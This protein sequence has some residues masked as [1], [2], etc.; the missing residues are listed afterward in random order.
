MKQQTNQTAI[1]WKEVKF[2]EFID[3]ND[4]DHYTPQY[5]DQGVPLI[6][7]KDFQDA[8][9]NLT[10]LKFVS[11]KELDNF[12][13]KCNPKKGDIL[14]S[15]IGTIGVPKIIDFDFV[16]LHSIAVIKSK[17]KEIDNKFLYYLLKSPEIKR[18]AKEGTKSIGTPDLGLNEIRNFKIKIPFLHGSPDLETQQKIV[19][20]LEKAEQL[21]EKRKQTLKLL[22]EYLKSVFNEMFVGKGF[23]KRK[24]NELFELAYGKGLSDKERDG[25]KYQVYGS[26]GVVGNHSN[27]LVDGPGIIIGRKGS[28]GE[29]NFT[30]DSFWPIDT[31]YYIKPK[32][33]FNLIFL[34]YLLKIYN[35]KLNTS[36]AI[37]G[38]NRNDV[39]SISFIYPPLVLQQTFASIVE[40]VEKLKETQKKSLQDIEQ[41]FNV[42]MQKAFN[43]EL[44]K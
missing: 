42:L 9:I 28:I 36:T 39:Y 25:G 19:A 17:N 11:K 15:R 4:R 8:G 21:K 40:H 5:F 35:L 43:G 33:K 2:K 26:N 16:A 10:K 6:S 41:L 1:E 12:V 7:P 27:Y 13:R 14:Y 20:I 3:V 29:I 30:K 44:V 24:G 34:F 22:D 18:Q 23:E 32:E 31:T 38:L 37:P